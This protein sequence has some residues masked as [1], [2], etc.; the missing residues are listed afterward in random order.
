M[1]TD[2]KTSYVFEMDSKLGAMSIKNDIAQDAPIVRETFRAFPVE[3]TPR[4]NFTLK[5]PH[6]EFTLAR[7]GEQW[8]ILVSKVDSNVQEIT[9]DIKQGGLQSKRG[10]DGKTV[11]SISMP[12][13]FASACVQ[14]YAA[15]TGKQHTERVHVAPLAAQLQEAIEAEDWAKVKEL[16][17]AIKAEKAKRDEARAA[18]NAAKVASDSNAIGAPASAPDAAPDTHAPASAPDTNKGK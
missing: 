2:S 14:A 8:S 5:T 11:E 12:L 9:R 6:G 18:A 4:V 3:N 13:S 1:N 10:K 7:N 16:N 15:L 17:A